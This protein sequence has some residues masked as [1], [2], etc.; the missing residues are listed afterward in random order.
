MG[1]VHTIAAGKPRLAR[2]K[3][4]RHQVGYR[5]GRNGLNVR[6]N[7]LPALIEGLQAAADKARTAGLLTDNESDAEAA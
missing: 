2:T 1:V 4:D 7:L 6:V 5:P 3:P